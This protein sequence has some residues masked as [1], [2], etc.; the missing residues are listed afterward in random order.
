MGWAACR[1]NLLEA[2]PLQC[3]KCLELGH[4]QQRCPSAADRSKCC[5]RCG[6][7]GHV[8][9]AHK[10]GSPQLVVSPKEK[11]EVFPPSR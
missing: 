2:R 8:A 6:G 7:E 1:V 5:Y 9:A 3:Y 11:E 4:V 10:L